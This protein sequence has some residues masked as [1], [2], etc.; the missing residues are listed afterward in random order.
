MIAAAV[1]LYD[2]RV[3]RRFLPRFRHVTLSRI[4]TF[5]LSRSSREIAFS[6]LSL[7]RNGNDRPRLHR[8]GAVFTDFRAPVAAYLFSQDVTAGSA[9]GGSM[10]KNRWTGTRGSAGRGRTGGR[11]VS[12]EKARQSQSTAVGSDGDG[13]L[14]PGGS[15]NFRRR[16]FPQYFL[17]YSINFLPSPPYFWQSSLS[18]SRRISSLPSGRLSF[19]I[20][21][22][23]VASAKLSADQTRRK[24]KS[25]KVTRGDAERTRVERK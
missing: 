11:P 13:R 3:P 8:A 21:L 25:M 10:P 2:R 20:A 22:R 17:P 4:E 15:S 18:P 16:V 5:L 12:R 7:S 23:P 1:A 6:R 24:R 14:R 19:A 9:P